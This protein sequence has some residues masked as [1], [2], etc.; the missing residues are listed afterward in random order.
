MTGQK[1]QCQR[2]ESRKPVRG[3]MQEEKEQDQKVQW[4]KM[5]KS[6]AESRKIQKR[7]AR[8]FAVAALM[9]I[10]AFLM[11][12]TFSA[13]GNA[14]AT[15]NM[16]LTGNTD[17]GENAQLDETYIETQLD[18]LDTESVENA[19]PEEA[20]DLMNGSSVKDYTT[21]GKVE[22]SEVLGTI[23]KNAGGKLE[24]IVKEGIKNV[25]IVLVI[26]IICAMASSFVQSG[27]WTNYISLASA[28]A[29]SAAAI[30]NVK[31]F[32]NLGSGIID[33]LD[34]FSKALIPTLVAAVTASGAPAS[35]TAKSAAIVLFI[36]IFI[37]VAKNVIMPVI[38]AYMGVAIAGAAMG[39]SQ[40]DG[41][42]GFLK[43]AA[44]S[45]MTVIMLT[46]VAY[47][48]ITGIIAETSD[49]V[50]V[51]AVKTVVSTALPVVGGILAD[52]AATVSS[53]VGVLKNAIG[54]FGALAVLAICL[55]PFLRLG[56]HY[57]MYKAVAALTSSIAGG[58]ISKLVASI[59]TA[60][61]IILGLVGMCA[62]M[63][64]I[65][66]ISTIKAV[67]L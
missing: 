2:V 32:V 36:D 55:I 15:E 49:A 27:K 52:A 8:F 22:P 67:G 10:F 3:K 30:G 51:R 17:F 28:A 41:A 62:V 37:T 6:E 4:R 44:V 19:L 26:G 45:M 50:T 23:A 42:A 5:Q 7:T 38:F 35:G 25:I 34:T 43:W 48:T 63:L 46:F 39:T 24:G 18:A 40:L 29:I 64:F 13:A 11:I 60:F 66:T 1:V 61:G 20:R 9:V 56:T 14:Y 57:L 16:D 47:L 33:Q 54:V 31:S 59:G 12:W 58:R 21:L 53:G 65:S